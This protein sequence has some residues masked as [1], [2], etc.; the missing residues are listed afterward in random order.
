MGLLD[1]LKNTLS[2]SAKSAINSTINNALGG[3]TGAVTSN[4]SSTISKSV[5]EAANAI[6]NNVS[7][8]VNNTTRTFKF[9]RIP[10]SL[11]ELKALPEAKLTDY[12]ASAALAVLVL[13]VCA[14]DKE[15]GLQMMDFLN[16]P[17]EITGQDRQ[18]IDTQFMDGKN[19]IPRSYFKGATPENNYTPDVPYEVS[20]TEN[21]Y[22]K[23]NFAEGYIT[24][25]IDS[26]GADSPRNVGLRT[27]KSTGEWFLNSY[28][29]LLTDIRIP[30]EKDA[31]A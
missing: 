12:F 17:N 31:W 30:V 6:K 4:L 13:N 29:S 9:N 25:W 18:F 3:K 14:T 24:L 23:D 20:V 1:S 11:E 2:S 10:T 21:P 19:Y 8:S 15:L 28:K 7:K 27:K 22:S 5:N 26:N 16:G